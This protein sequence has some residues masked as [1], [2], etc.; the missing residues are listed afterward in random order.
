M[1]GG[2]MVLHQDEHVQASLHYGR[3]DAHGEK[4]RSSSITGCCWREFADGSQEG[5]SSYERVSIYVSPL[6]WLLYR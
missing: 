2:I 4:P 1:D 6:T 3:N 5:C